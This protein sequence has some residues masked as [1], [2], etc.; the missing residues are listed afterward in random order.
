MKY[1]SCT[2]YWLNKENL[3]LRGEFET[4]YQDIDDPWGCGELSDS[5]DNKIFCEIIFHNRKFSNI[6]DIGSG[7]GKLTNKLY[8]YN[9]GGSPPLS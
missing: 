5:I 6:L 7:L 1:K 4:M 8:Q 9:G 3:S 2:D